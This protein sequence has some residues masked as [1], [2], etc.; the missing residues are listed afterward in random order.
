M[1]KKT[2]G[3]FGEFPFATADFSKVWGDLKVPGFDFDVVFAAQ[4]K[5]FE[6]V[7]A[8]NRVAVEGL[9]TVAK[10]QAELFQA[11][12]DAFQKASTDLMATTEVNDRA[13]KQAEL[14]QA[15]LTKTA[16]ETGLANAQEL[17]DLVSKSTTETLAVVNKRVAE[18]I[19]EVQTAIKGLHA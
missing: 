11:S 3:G 9:Q 5:N 16:F 18:G 12:V 19:D 13:V 14:K 2:N 17:S 10:R 7:T 1:T 15:E 6:A 4:Q 8:A